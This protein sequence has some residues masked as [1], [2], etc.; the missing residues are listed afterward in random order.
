MDPISPGIIS[1]LVV[2]ALGGGAGAISRSIMTRRKREVES[3]LVTLE[4]S[5]KPF[6]LSALA[7]LTEQLSTS[8]INGISNF[9]KSP[10]AD[11]AVRGIAVSILAKGYDRTEADHKELFSTLLQLTGNL[12]AP[13]AEASALPLVKI[14]A[15]TLHEASNKVFQSNPR[16]H[17]ELAD[18]AVS[19]KNSGV[20]TRAAA[21]NVRFLQFES[22]D[23]IKVK[24]F[25]EAYRPALSNRTNE[26]VP[27]YFDVQTR[28]PI[29]P[30]Y[31]VPRFER[32]IGGRTD[33]RFYPANS[34]LTFTQMISSAYRTVILGDPGAG[35]STLTQKLAYEFSRNDG[36]SYGNAVPFIVT[37]RSYEEAK[38]AR[39]CSL[40]E[41]LARHLNESYHLI[42]KPE[43]LEYIFLS[44]RGLVMFDGL[45][46]LIDVTRRREMVSIIEN[47]SN[48]YTATTIIVT[49]RTVGYDEAPVSPKNFSTLCLM[50][51]SD[52]DVAE[53]AKN[54]FSIDKNLTKDEHRGLTSSFLHESQSVADIR[55]NALM[56][57][58]LCN[59][60]RGIRTIPED[61]ADLYEKCAEMLFERWDAGRGVSSS[62][63]LRADA[64]AALQDVALWAYTSTDHAKGIPRSTLKRRLTRFWQ[65]RYENIEDAETAATK[66]LKLWSG[67][68]WILTD[69]GTSES[70]REE[71]YKFTHRTFLEYFAACELVKCNPSPV[72]LWKQLAPRLYE[73]SWDIVSQLAIQ[74]LDGSYS[75][76][77]DKT[78]NLLLDSLTQVN[79]FTRTN[80]LSFASR[81][82][83]GLYIKTT[84]CR[85]LVRACI[86]LFLEGIPSMSEMP[87]FMAY[88]DETQQDFDRRHS[89]G[90]QGDD[91]EWRI[92]GPPHVFEPLFRMI[93]FEG[94][95]KSVVPLE[96]VSYSK[97]LLHHPSAE[98]GARAFLLIASLKALPE[99]AAEHS[100]TFSPEQVA[101]SYKF[102]WHEEV[103][104]ANLVSERVKYWSAVSFWVPIMAARSR[105]I[106]LVELLKYASVDALVCTTSPF[107]DA[108]KDFRWPAFA[109]TILRGYLGFSAIADSEGYSSDDIKNCLK[110]IGESLSEQDFWFRLD[111][112]WGTRSD[113]EDLILKSVFMEPE[114][115]SS[116]YSAHEVGNKESYL[117]ED[118]NASL[119][120]AFLLCYYIETEDWIISDYSAD[121]VASLRLGP[122]DAL[123][124][125][126]IARMNFV[127][128]DEAETALSKS[129]LDPKQKEILLK[130]VKKQLKVAA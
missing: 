82:L 108:T 27:A 81:N 41:F 118:I 121:Q 58:L 50:N 115:G 83:D 119:G 29:N 10:E 45:D 42:V 11:V 67:R 26:L 39:G 18:R 68:T 64:K 126:F 97:T 46:E 130:W 128:I 65:R 38:R 74:K 95:L 21:R 20:L 120:A 66:L 56:L 125:V 104:V 94:T 114:D 91:E 48:L 79:I 54:W 98:I 129:N 25:I 14:V 17:G 106:S 57:G 53:Y 62:R 8:E 87:S 102:D 4:T 34:A 122:L 9:L 86:D 69:V 103:E 99:L 36:N 85:R 116:G 107:P 70:K 80:L 59:V 15:R 78:V 2:R 28:V 16:L 112:E 76:A 123:E 88:E 101:D 5:A 55:Q 124:A 84:T 71:I 1:G 19:D 109:E 93:S 23:L 110:L 61:R 22:V 37:M 72:K 44:G 92:F 77:A 111:S 43:I 6:I 73:G 24:Q 51:F 40:I 52:T 47:F 105:L 117:L 75:D 13:S 33:S 90:H 12:S 96:V 30:H 63:P 35:K 3:A 113:L 100:K 49:S 7:E 60:Y 31:V 89:I 127:F 32:R